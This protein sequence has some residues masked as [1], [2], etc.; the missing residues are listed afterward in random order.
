MM[1]DHQ[2]H[3]HLLLTTYTPDPAGPD[4]LYLSIQSYPHQHQQ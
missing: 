3:A 1:I 4:R 2:H